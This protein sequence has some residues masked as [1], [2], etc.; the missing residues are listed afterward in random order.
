[1]HA[2]THMHAHTQLLHRQVI[3]IDSLVS[4]STAC[5]EVN[6]ENMP[7]LCEDILKSALFRDDINRDIN[8]PVRDYIEEK[9]C[10]LQAKGAVGAKPAD[11]DKSTD[12]SDTDD[13]DD[14]GTDKTGTETGRNHSDP[15]RKRGTK[16][17]QVEHIIIEEENEHKDENSEVN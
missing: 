5:W 1:M 4:I 9:L 7:S 13:T 15:T 11:T 16:T 17:P 12:K 2:H 8:T 3:A 10:L 14:T 6:E